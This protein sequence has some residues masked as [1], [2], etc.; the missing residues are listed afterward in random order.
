VIDAPF[1]G[2]V[3]SHCHR[4]QVLV[5]HLCS[6]TRYDI[7]GK[8]DSVPAFGRLVPLRGIESPSVEGYFT[9]KVP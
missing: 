3:P 4:E 1:S 6:V 8:A 9:K 5:P 2:Y 7:A